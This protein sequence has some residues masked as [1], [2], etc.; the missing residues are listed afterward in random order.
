MAV[1][2]YLFVLIKVHLRQ[3]YF[4]CT[5]NFPDIFSAVYLLRILFLLWAAAF[6][7]TL[8]MENIFL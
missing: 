1:S 6:E 7:E 4:L 3:H 5:I 2:F 8:L